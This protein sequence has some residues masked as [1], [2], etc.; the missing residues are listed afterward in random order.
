M[1]L[2]IDTHKEYSQ[3]SVI[4]GD[5]NLQDEIHLPND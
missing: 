3:V 4:N 1:Y 2:G 5:G